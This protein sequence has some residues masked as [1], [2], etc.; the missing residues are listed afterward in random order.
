ML[1]IEDS[2]LIIIDI[3]E[4]LVLASK[5]GEEVANNMTKV[6]KDLTNPKRNAILFYI[7]FK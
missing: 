2:I 1:N 5:Y 6:A 3:Q 4:R 7:S